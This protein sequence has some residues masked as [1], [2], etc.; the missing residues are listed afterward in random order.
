MQ[1][2]KFNFYDEF[3]CTGAEC[4]D[5]CCQRW[6]I[7][8]SRREWLDFKRMECSPELRAVLDSSFKKTKSDSSDTY[9]RIVFRKDGTCPLLGEDGLCM[10]QKE[11]GESALT[12]ICSTFPRIW[13]QVAGE[14]EGEE[15]DNGEVAVFTLTLTCCHAVE[16]LMQH[17]E[18]LALVQEEYDRKNK[19][20]NLNRWSRAP[21]DSDAETHPYIW[22]IKTAQLDI[23]Q[24]REFTVAERLLI[25]GYY[26]QRVC[27][28][29]E[30]S[31]EKIE[32]LG[33]MI[34]DGELCRKVVDSLKTHQTDE[35]AITKANDILFK[36]TIVARTT[37]PDSSVTEL[38]NTVADSVGLTYGR[39]DGGGYNVQWRSNA[40]TKNRA[41]YQKIEDE[42]PYIFENLLA[43][44]AFST[45][46]R[47]GAELWADYSTLAALYGF[48][49]IGIAAFLPESC[50]DRELAAAITKLVKMLINSGIARNLM[51]KEHASG[52]AN[53]LPYIAS[54]IG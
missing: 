50:T 4:A 20:I 38:L 19:W 17:P 14:G 15:E 43:A 11:K 7:Y 40:C 37:E 46:S 6:N 53:S 33:T 54:L 24:N 5:T 16:L 8:L 35:Q 18:G 10:L 26:T 9:A 32:Q 28:Y 44:L 52:D 3:A 29:L 13:I 27:E 2:L 42:R 45:F 36:L 34:L 23:L 41:L 21:V 30:S 12:S 48:L 51:M 39:G 31:P 49:K 25:L 47:S 22:S 1:T